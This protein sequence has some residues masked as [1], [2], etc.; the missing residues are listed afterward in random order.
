MLKMMICCV[1]VILTII[2]CGQTEMPAT[3]ILT[4]QIP[5]S[6]FPPGCVEGEYK[7][8]NVLNKQTGLI[9]MELAEICGWDIWQGY[10]DNQLP[11][12]CIDGD[13]RYASPERIGLLLKMQAGYSVAGWPKAVDTFYSK[14]AK[15]QTAELLVACIAMKQLEP[16]WSENW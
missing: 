15:E 11:I 3:E 7:E 9:E 14:N 2:A 10:Y 5:A 12:S 16:R 1:G 13:W 8:T 6:H 4:Y